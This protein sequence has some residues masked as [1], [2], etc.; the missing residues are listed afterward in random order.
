VIVT[1]IPINTNIRKGGQDG[2]REEGREGGRREGKEGEREEGK[3]GGRKGKRRGGRGREVQ[4]I[5]VLRIGEESRRNRSAQICR[6]QMTIANND[7]EQ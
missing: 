1:Q 4:I 3:E 2:G 5:E 7:E 6:A